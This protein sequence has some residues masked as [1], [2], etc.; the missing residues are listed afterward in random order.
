MV[1]EILGGKVQFLG[2][3]WHMRI[4]IEWKTAENSSGK[5]NKIRN[6]DKLFGGKHLQ[7]THLIKEYFLNIKR[8]LK[9][10]WRQNNLINKWA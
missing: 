4:S 8:A 6:K 1:W 3:Q 7:K 10:Q 2:N 5:Y 9:A